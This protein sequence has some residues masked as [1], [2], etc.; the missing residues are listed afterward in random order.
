MKKLLLSICAILALG[1]VSCGGGESSSSDNYY[2]ED[3]NSGGSEITFKGNPDGLSYQ[4]E[5]SA[6][7]G[8]NFMTIYVY[9]NRNGK[10]VAKIDPRHTQTFAITN[11]SD[12]YTRDTYNKKI[13]Y[14]RC[15]WLFS[16]Y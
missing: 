8:D 15:Y 6:R 12:F 10:L 2:Y 4:G 14:Q 1:L 16:W 5:T 7:C 9:E 13:E 11:N 3:N